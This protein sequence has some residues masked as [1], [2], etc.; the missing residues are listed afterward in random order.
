MVS[1]QTGFI[2][3]GIIVFIAIIIVLVVKTK[4]TNNVQDVQY[5]T[6]FSMG[7]S[8]I[9]HSIQYNEP[10]MLTIPLDDES[11][12]EK[13]SSGED[14]IDRP[15]KIIENYPSNENRSNT[16]LVS[17]VKKNKYQLW[18][19]TLSDLRG[20]GMW[21]G[22]IIVIA[23]DFEP[24]PNLGELYKVTF[25]YF[26]PY[27]L[28]K[29]KEN[30][31]ENGF[32]DGQGIELEE[33]PYELLHIFGKW[34]KQWNRIVCVQ[35]GLRILDN[36]KMILDIP[37]QGKVLATNPNE[38]RPINLEQSVLNLAREL[39]DD[40]IHKNLYD[41][42]LEECGGIENIRKRS[43][44]SSQLLIFDTDALDVK[45]ENRD[46]VTDYLAEHPNSKT[47][48][49]GVLTLLFHYKYKI[50]EYLPEKD[51]TDTKYII[52]LSESRYS[53]TIKWNDFIFLLFSSSLSLTI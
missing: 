9:I 11:N 12:I 53:D 21:S 14:S 49:D 30:I 35:P 7:F 19:R 6:S 44:V 51:R 26:N 39:S 38:P 46:F 24:P 22:D 2:I 43:S 1:N 5:Q 29:W 4:E 13:S 45:L 50:L 40:I 25:V 27:D 20:V 23:E 31:P 47:L 33:N 52:G 16:V 17:Y 3:I 10:K 32:M 48:V 8:P 36:I 28:K 41:E 34:F 42:I 37:Y 15:I 18:R